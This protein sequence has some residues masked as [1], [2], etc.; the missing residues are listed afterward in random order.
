[1]ERGGAESTSVLVDIH[2]CE[3]GRTCCRLSGAPRQSDTICESPAFMLCSLVGERGTPVICGVTR[4]VSGVCS[5]LYVESETRRAG[6]PGTA[7]T[8][9]ISCLG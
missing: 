1:M 9:A 6:I 2:L 4:S 8:E 5:A 3:P 7:V